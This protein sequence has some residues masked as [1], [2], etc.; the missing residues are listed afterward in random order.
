MI[1]GIFVLEKLTS[2]KIRLLVDLGAN[3]LFIGHKNIDHKLALETKNCGLKLN[4]EIGLFAGSD[5]WKKYPE[6]IPI[7]KDGNKASIVDWYAG[8]CPN[9][10]RVKK[11]KL[12]EIKNIIKTIPI[13]GLWL[14]FIR[15]PCHWEDVRN[16][17]IT[18]YC[19]CPVCRS[20]YAKD[21]GADLKTNLWYEWKCTQIFKFAKQARDI[22]KNNNKNISLGLFSVPW[23]RNEYGKAIKRVVGQDFEKLAEVVDVFSPM[24]YHHMCGRPVEWIRETVCYFD[25]ITRKQILPLVQTE[26]KPTHISVRD[27]KR[28]LT[29]AKKSPSS[30]VVVFFLENLL[31]DKEKTSALK[32]F[33]HS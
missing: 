33:F 27:F 19:F 6:S 30:G 11:E 26:N 8:V 23:K 16:K 25:K 21:V 18:E 22:I 12:H 13:D 3:T 2:E 4:V 28:S 20:K 24:T 31:K 14:D 29:S 7:D 17:I 15:Y 1:K 9:N 10:P 5:L 32:K